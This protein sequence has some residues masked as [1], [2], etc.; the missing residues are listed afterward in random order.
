MKK[1]LGVMAAIM[2]VAILAVTFIAA[3]SSTAGDKGKDSRFIAYDDGTVLDTG[4]NLM[5]AAKDNSNPIN[6]ANAK[7]YCD[8]YRAGGYTDWRMPTLPELAGLYNSGKRYKATQMNYTVG[9]TEMIQLSSVAFGLRRR[10]FQRRQLRFRPWHGALGFPVLRRQTSGTSSAFRQIDYA[11]GYL[12]IFFWVHGDAP[13][14]S[15]VNLQ[16]C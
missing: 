6:W 2:V 7:S 9:L 10:G 13:C 8:D 16:F 15:L 4:T 1:S 11:F 3:K 5:W 14:L 12:I